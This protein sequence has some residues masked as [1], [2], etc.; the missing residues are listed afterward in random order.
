[1]ETSTPNIEELAIPVPDQKDGNSSEDLLLSAFLYAANLLGVRA[2]RYAV[3]TGLGLDNDKV[4][5]PSLAEIS[6]RLGLVASLKKPIKNVKKIS[7]PFILEGKD[8]RILVVENLTEQTV[9][10]V[11]IG[12]DVPFQMSIQDLLETGQDHW[13]T[14]EIDDEA[15]SRSRRERSKHGSWFWSTLWKA[16]SEYTKVIFASFLVNSL[17]IAAPLFTL[18]VYDRV[19]PNSAF[20]T[21]WV[22]AIGMALVIVFDLI[23]RA[24][25]GAVVDSTGR[26]ADVRLASNIYDHV[27]R[28]DLADRPARAGEFANRLR[29][30]ESVRDFFSSSTIIALLDLLFVSLF[31]IVIYF[32]GGPMVY[33][34]LAAVA[35][36]LL[37]GVIAQPLMMKSVRDVQEE[38]ALKHGLLIET[39]NGLSTIKSLNAE[40][41]FLRRW[42]KYV[43]RTAR[44]TE[45]VRFVSQNLLNITLT[46]QQ[47]VTIGLI[48]FG[49]YLFDAGLLSMGGIIATVMLS[50]R[51]IAPLASIAGTFSRLQQSLVSLKNL[52]EIMAGRLENET[53]ELGVSREIKSGEIVFENV[54]FVYPESQTPALSE[55]GVRIPAGAKVGVIGKIGAGKSTLVGV[56][57]GLYRATSG[58]IKVDGINLSQLHTRDLREGLGYV[59]QDVTLFSGTI[60]DNIVMGSPHLNDADI[61]K[62]ANLT[63]ASE[64]IDAHPMGYGQHVGEGGRCLS[65]GQRQLISLTRSLARDPAVLVLDEPTS[66]MDVGSETVFL[67]RLKAAIGTRTLIIS[68]HRQSVLGL[69]DFL[70]VMEKGRVAAFGPKDKVL[71]F[72]EGK[73]AKPTKGRS[74]KKPITILPLS[75]NEAV[76]A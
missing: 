65:G 71:A 27:L 34:P 51:A 67:N 16:R 6:R 60:R 72:L 62:A 20:S 50:S 49:T 43:S 55:I 24:L 7:F 53:T 61:I 11:E 10:G 33:L 25:R 63:G 8:H 59:G 40:D 22:L 1:M 64:F 14:L 36:V 56:L 21:L 74:N 69:V 3:L 13:I 2:S 17:A 39:I 66:A 58:S 68:T 30:F 32:V 75:P 46:T 4:D 23:F 44:S 15:Q 47:A 31:L 42:Q 41:H 28:M 45:K 9:S 70:L 18:N 19:L 57:A 12:T 37:V 26:W 29:D 38:S 76:N 35:I 48:I 52:N 5:F 54:S 73:T